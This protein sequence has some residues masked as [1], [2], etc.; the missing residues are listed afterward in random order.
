MDNNFVGHK[1]IV[2]F[3]IDGKI[4]SDANIPSIRS[5][6]EHGLVS[7]MNSK[8]YVPHFDIEPAFSL[9]YD[10]DGGYQFLL[11]M[12]GVFVGR[13]KAKCYH[14]VSLNK[15]IPKNSTQKNK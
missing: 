8:G 13:A 3:Q 11:S 6:F 10:D 9:E 15:L 14:G 12:H 5:R 1:K 2:M 7:I 4:D